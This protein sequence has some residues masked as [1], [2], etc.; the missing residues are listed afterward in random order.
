[1]L[2][3]GYGLGARHGRPLRRILAAHTG[4]L[5]LGLFFGTVTLAVA[6]RPG[7]RPSPWRSSAGGRC[8]YVVETIGKSV[9]AIAWLTWLSPFHYYAEG[10]PLYQ[11]FPVGDYLVLA[12]A[13]RVL[14]SPR[15]S[16]SIRRDV[17]V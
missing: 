3:T 15:S 10:Q 6:P 2:V 5:L 17:G 12:G 11:G 4:V 1:M 8:G 9:E 14:L 13:T 16:P 7:A